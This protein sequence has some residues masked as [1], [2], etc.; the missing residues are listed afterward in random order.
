MEHF[1]HGASSGMQPLS[2]T[3]LLGSD[4]VGQ[5]QSENDQ[6]LN[7]LGDSEEEHQ[8]VCNHLNPVV[9]G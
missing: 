3:N 8:S 6:M 5:E 9:L 4:Q 2:L 7:M 1:E